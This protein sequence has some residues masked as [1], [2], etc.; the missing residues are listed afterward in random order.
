MTK[1]DGLTSRSTESVTD[2]LCHDL[3][4]RSSSFLITPL[5]DFILPIGG[6]S[7]L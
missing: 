4:G 3:W 5:T 2:W 1:I 6:D 7:Q